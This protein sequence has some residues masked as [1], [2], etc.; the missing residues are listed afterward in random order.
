MKYFNLFSITLVALVTFSCQEKKLQDYSVTENGLYYKLHT[1]GGQEL[2]PQLGDLLTLHIVFKTEKDSILY[3]SAKKVVL[4][5][6][7]YKGSIEE[8]LLLLSL[9][10][11]AT[12]K[13]KADSFYSK[14]I[15]KPLPSFISKNSYLTV[16]VKIIDIALFTTNAVISKNL[17]DDYEFKDMDELTLVSMYLK[18]NNIHVQP[19]AG[20]L[21]FIKTKETS[22]RKAQ[23][24]HG[25]KIHYSGSFLDGKIFDSTFEREI[26][27]EFILGTKDQVIPGIEQ[28]LLLMNEG[29][30]ASL[31]IPSFL[32]FGEKGSSTGFIP[33]FTPVKY[34]VELLKVN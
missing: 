6:S 4:S 15:D 30:K 2:Y 34:E 3:K 25:V 17:I 29:E 22:G 18:E 14:G 32:A 20:G 8:G 9:G 33:P 13:I 21:Y 11:S 1:I 31:I 28:A 27:F 5:Q 12:F 26:P 16:G 7:P 24:G 10:D 19:T 23:T